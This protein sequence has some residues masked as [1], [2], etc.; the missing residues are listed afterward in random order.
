MRPGAH[1]HGASSSLGTTVSSPS[2]A[3]PRKTRER[4]ARRQAASALSPRTVDKD[5]PSP[6]LPSFLPAPPAARPGAMPCPLAQTRPA[7]LPEGPLV[8]HADSPTA[9]PAPQAPSRRLPAF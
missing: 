3:L 6:K 7:C 8:F 9:L 1:S 2:P 5:G 4:I